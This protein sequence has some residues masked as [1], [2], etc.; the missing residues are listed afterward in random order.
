MGEQKD[1]EFDHIDTD[2]KEAERLIS[3]EELRTRL[4]FLLSEKPELHYHPEKVERY[5]ENARCSDDIVLIWKNKN[6]D[7]IIESEMLDRDGDAIRDN[8][9]VDTL[10]HD[11]E[12]TVVQIAKLVAKYGEPQSIEYTRFETLTRLIGANIALSH[13]KEFYYSDVAADILRLAR[14]IDGNYKDMSLA[15]IGRILNDTEKQNN[16]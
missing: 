3:E 14:E 16:I 2:D 13:K 4:F 11:A 10:F 15:E 1:S 12:P 6:D 7:S 9:Y 5:G 8:I